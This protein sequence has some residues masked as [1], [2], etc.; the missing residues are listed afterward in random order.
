MP[1]DQ[2]ERESAARPTPVHMNRSSKPRNDLLAVRRRQLLD[3]RRELVLVQPVDGR[4]GSR[5]LKR[6]RG[7]SDDVQSLP[8]DRLGAQPERGVKAQ[9]PD[10]RTRSDVDR[11]EAQLA[12]VL[13]E[14]DVSDTSQALAVEVDDLRVEHVPPE[15]KRVLRLLDAGCVAEPDLGLERFNGA[16]GMPTATNDEMGDDGVHFRERRGEIPKLSDALAS[17]TDHRRPEDLR[18]PA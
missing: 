2:P 3:E 15:Q 1:P 14:F 12:V 13:D 17:R 5:E 6:M 11:G 8:V 4:R 16:P 10:N 7:A 18:Q 9:P